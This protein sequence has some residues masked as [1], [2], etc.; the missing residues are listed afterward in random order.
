MVKSS[1]SGGNGNCV[2]V[3]VK[4]SFSGNSGNCVNVGHDKAENT[5]EVTDEHGNTTYFNRDEWDA[6]IKGVKN[7]EFDWEVLAGE[8]SLS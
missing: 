2:D 1:F 3:T 7:N 8:P 4:S 5:L 6:F